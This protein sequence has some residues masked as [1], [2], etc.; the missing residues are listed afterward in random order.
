MSGR[1][2]RLRLCGEEGV[3]DVGLR[4]VGRLRTLRRL[5][6]SAPIR[7]SLM[8]ESLSVVGLAA[9]SALTSLTELNLSGNACFTSVGA[10]PRALAWPG[11]W[12]AIE[13]VGLWGL[14]CC[15]EPQQLQ[16]PTI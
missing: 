5:E 16:Q 11:L 7:R 1:E 15:L 9:L 14:H 13:Y 2:R 4:A 8:H 3:T 10:R 6:F 12:Q